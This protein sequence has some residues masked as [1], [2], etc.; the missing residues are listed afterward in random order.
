MEIIFPRQTRPSDS[1]ILNTIFH[2]A[3]ISVSCLAEEST[4][5]R[6]CERDGVREMRGREIG[7]GECRLHQDDGGEKY[8]DTSN[9]SNLN[10]TKPN[11]NLNYSKRLSYTVLK[12]LL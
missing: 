2:G 5:V 1:P 7:G 3:N 10:K 9:S 8:I 11:L 6:E 4:H 12:H